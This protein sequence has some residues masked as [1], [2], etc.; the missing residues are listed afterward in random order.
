MSK[1]P[2]D[3]EDE[4]DDQGNTLFPWEIG[5]DDGGED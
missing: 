1:R 2:F 3:D 4:E 5:G